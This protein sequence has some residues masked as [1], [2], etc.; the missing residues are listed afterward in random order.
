MAVDAKTRLS[1]PYAPLYFSTADIMSLAGCHHPLDR[2]STNDHASV[3]DSGGKVP[4]LA[5]QSKLHHLP[6]RL[7][8]R[9]IT[10]STTVLNHTS[11]DPASTLQAAQQASTILARASSVST[12]FPASLLNTADTPELWAE[13]ERLLFACLR[14]GDDKSAFLCLEKL[15]E[16]FGATNEKIMALR[17]LYQEAVAPNNEALQEI[18]SDYN[19]ILSENPMNAPIHKRR[20]ALIKSLGRREQ[21]I[22]NLVDFLDAFPT[23]V[24]AWAELSEL[25]VSQGLLSQA[26][27]SLE[28]AV[29][30]TP[31]AWN[32][33]ARLGELEYLLGLS[34]EGAE[35]QKHLMQAV[36]RF[37]RSIEL[38][39]DYL[40]G[41]YGL[42]LACAQL[43][44]K[45]GSQK[46]ST[47]P[48]ISQDKLEKLSRLASSKLEAIVKE[49]L[50]GNGSR[51]EQPELIAAQELLSRSDK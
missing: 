12:T 23:D 14:T 10:M 32:L 48:T 30:A 21:A 17:G 22:S 38:C 5:K 35:G 19:K 2:L 7:L 20:T 15:T 37:S 11:S 45:T 31:N 3:R 42:K 44:Q 24:E 1:L 40:R 13:L 25:Y 33:H 46:G 27:F 8:S 29:I 51:V 16:R 34:L 28:E 18:L 4:S 26:I 9:E 47:T 36:Q 49:R 43:L 6:S 41:F 50:N 39:D